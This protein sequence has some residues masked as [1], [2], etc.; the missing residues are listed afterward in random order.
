MEKMFSIS[1][2][3]HSEKF[4]DE[5]PEKLRELIK[6]PSPP[7]AMAQTDRTDRTNRRP[8]QKVT[9]TKRKT[10]FTRR[11]KENYYESKFN[12]NIAKRQG[13]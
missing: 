1:E 12:R 13:K 3:L 9:K 5:L 4:Q 8:K 10:P 6:T 7:L 11:S 2:V